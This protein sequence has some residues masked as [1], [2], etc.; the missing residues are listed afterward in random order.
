M[1]APLPDFDSLSALSPPQEFLD[2]ASAL[3]IEFEGS[4]LARLGL[5]L[6]A[7]LETNK[8][9]NLTAI[10][11]EKEAWTRHIL[12]SLTLLAPLA[13]LSEQ[14]RVIDVGSGGGLPGIPLAIVLP[15]VRFTLLEATGKKAE[16][17][18][19]MVSFLKLSNAVVVQERAERAAHQ[20][21]EKSD[22]GAR[23]GGHREAYDAVVA[24]AVGRLHSLAE[25]TVPFAKA[26]AAGQAAGLVLLIKGQKAEEE[27]VEAQEALH[28]LKAVH[29]TT[30]D[31]P[32][33][34]IVV[35]EKGAATP[36]IYPRADG[37]PTRVPLGAARPERA[38]SGPMTTPTPK[39]VA[40]PVTRPVPKP[41]PK[42]V[43]EQTPK[44]ISKPTP[45]PHSKPSTR[46]NTPGRRP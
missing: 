13:D 22:K 35:L 32:T 18:K 6:A 21:G 38:E 17:L 34:R 8:T 4:D 26:P 14:A 19:A 33:G 39:P 12:D 1:P 30:L 27:L 10:R 45:R 16:F 5:Y 23:T 7:L 43:S 37:E 46:P 15:S 9:T 44:P 11:D 2:A 29:T 28:V 31:T 41:I 3:G 20:R 24:R 25:L 42:P 36:R 40:T